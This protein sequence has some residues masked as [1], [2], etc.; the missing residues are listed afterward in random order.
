M[1]DATPYTETVT[2]S[3]TTLYRARFGGFAT[4]AQARAACTQIKRKK[5]DCIALQ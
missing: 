2:K 1:A 3:G 5:F 4:K